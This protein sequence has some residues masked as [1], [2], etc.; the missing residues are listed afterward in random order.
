MGSIGPAEIIVVL[1]VGLIVLGPN[2]LPEAARQIGKAVAEFRKVTSGLQA[3]V[4]DVFN[5]AAPGTVPTPPEPTSPA[6][7]EAVA[8]TEGEPTGRD[9]AARDPAAG[10]VTEVVATADTGP[11][12]WANPP[13]PVE[14]PAASNG[15]AVASGP[16]H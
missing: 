13:V 3:E 12:P 10:D 11:A 6:V 4:R 14:G 1:I 8:A 5:E 7:A 15:Q 2:R 16:E 9:P